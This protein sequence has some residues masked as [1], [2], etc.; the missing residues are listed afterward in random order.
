RDRFDRERSDPD[1]TNAS[2]AAAQPTATR[3]TTSIIK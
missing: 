2:L 1:A 3:T